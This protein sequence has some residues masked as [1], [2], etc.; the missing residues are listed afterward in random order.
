MSDPA[1]KRPP[2]PASLV[3]DL[4]ELTM[5]AAYQAEGIEHEATF[6]LFVRRMPPQRRFLVAAGLDDALAGLEA[7]RFAPH[8]VDYLAGLGLF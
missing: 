6:E 7:L 2:V 4:Y 8:E 1:P 5:A 3:T